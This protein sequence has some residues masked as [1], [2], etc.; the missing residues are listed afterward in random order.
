MLDFNPQRQW[1]SLANGWQG[2]DWLLFVMPS[3]LVLFSC[4]LLNSIQRSMGDFRYDINHFIIGAISLGIALWISRQRYEVLQDWNWIIYTIV[5][6]S[7]I[8][9]MFI[10][11]VGS[12]AQS[13]IGIGGFY[14]QPSEFAKVGLIITLAAQLSRRDASSLWGLFTA[15]G[16]TA[17]PWILIFIQ[18]D[19]GTSLVF[20]V[21]VMGMLYW[22]TVNLVGCCCWPLP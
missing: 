17:L 6:A 16:I 1:R 3:L 8:L 12:G 18:P 2:V 22:Q 11:T 9:V 10:G 14:I 15:L 5:N 19:L 7:L 20:G 13:W 21:I 4:V